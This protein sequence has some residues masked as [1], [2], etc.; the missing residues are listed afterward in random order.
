MLLLYPDELYRLLDSI[1]FTCIPSLKTMF[2]I[3]KDP[4]MQQLV[5]ILII[6]LG[7]FLNGN[8]RYNTSKNIIEIHK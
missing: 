1:C 3:E 6:F 4:S 5:S 2:I 8:K 7:I